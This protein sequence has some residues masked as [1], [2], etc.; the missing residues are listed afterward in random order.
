MNDNGFPV[1]QH[2]KEAN[3][4]K[5]YQF[6]PGISGSTSTQLLPPLM[7][8]IVLPQRSVARTYQEQALMPASFADAG[9]STTSPRRQSRLKL[10]PLPTINPLQVATFSPHT[11][12]CLGN[13]LRRPLSPTNLN[14]IPSPQV[15]V[16]ATPT[17]L[18]PR[19]LRSSK[20]ARKLPFDSP[21][22]RT[23][24]QEPADHCQDCQT[25]QKHC[26]KQNMKIDR[27]RN[28]LRWTIVNQNPGNKENTMLR[29]RGYTI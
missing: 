28:I 27:M 9:T 6:V 18:Q 17:V 8:Q 21:T 3:D 19:V 29:D 10:P 24:P 23:I 22:P 1:L 26:E 13:S 4:F 11:P 16:Q 15:P 12:S 20:A 2:V 5:R 25:L 14:Q 7:T